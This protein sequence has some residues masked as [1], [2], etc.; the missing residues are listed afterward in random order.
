MQRWHQ[1]GFRPAEAAQFAIPIRQP[2]LKD[3][4]HQVKIWKVEALKDGAQMTRLLENRIPNHPWNE[5]LYDTLQTS[6]KDLNGRI[7]TANEFV[8]ESKDYLGSVWAGS[9]NRLTTKR[10][11]LDWCLLELKPGRVGLNKVC[12]VETWKS[13]LE[14]DFLVSSSQISSSTPRSM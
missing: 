8:A 7:S 6:V 3:Y 13:E 1:E 10:R 11:T 5:A 9:G 14:T 12:P 4:D 2:S